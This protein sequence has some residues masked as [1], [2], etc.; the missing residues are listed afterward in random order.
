MSIDYFS[1]GLISFLLLGSN[2]FWAK[3]CA[4]LTDKLMSRDFADYVQA[5]KYR[6][7]VNKKTSDIVNDD[8]V[9]DPRDEAQAQQLN[10][11]L[12]IA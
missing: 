7:T 8:D 2:V 4:K 5:E 9:I 12:G 3:H 6:T 10:S 11:M 1:L